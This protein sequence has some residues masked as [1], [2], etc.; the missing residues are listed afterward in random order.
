MRRL[1]V[2]L[3]TAFLAVGSLQTPAQA[4]VTSY[5]T[6]NIIADLNP[7]TAYDEVGS[8]V[9]W[10]GAL[11]YVGESATYGR[12]LRRITASGVS[13][14]AYDVNPDGSSSPWAL[15]VFKGKLYFYA[16]SSDGTT[17]LYSLTTTGVLT[18]HGAIA[19]YPFWPMKDTIA[20]YNN[21]LYMLRHNQDGPESSWQLWQFDGNS[22]SLTPAPSHER[23][24]GMNSQW[25]SVV[26]NKLY[27]SMPAGG[28]AT[29]LGVVGTDGVAVQAPH[30]T[31]IG[32]PEHLVSL[33]NRIAL[34]AS[35]PVGTE[36][37]VYDGNSEPVGMNVA[38]DSGQVGSSWPSELYVY[39][40]N[41]YFS[42]SATPGVYEFWRTDGTSQPTR[43]LGSVFTSGVKVNPVP[44]AIFNNR[45]YF[46]ALTQGEANVGLFSTDGNTARRESVVPN[47]W[48]PWSGKNPVF[49]G[50]VYLTVD[51]GT[52]PILYSFD[53]T[54]LR[55]VEHTDYATGEGYAEAWGVSA[56]ATTSS[57]LYF[58]GSTGDHSGLFKFNGTTTPT[59]VPGSE[60][61]SV[62][63]IF[64]LGD[65]VYASAQPRNLEYQELALYTI[66]V[67]AEL[68]R[69]DNL[70]ESIGTNSMDIIASMGSG[71]IFVS[72]DSIVYL[73]NSQIRKMDSS[74]FDQIEVGVVIGSYYYF[75]VQEGFGK[76]IYRW[77]GTNSPTLYADFS[78]GF[79][80][81][82][83]LFDVNGELHC[84][85][86]AGNG[87][88]F[89]KIVPSGFETIDSDPGIDS[90]YVRESVKVG[91]AT[92]ITGFQ[93]STFTT[94]LWKLTSS[95]IAAV[96]S[97]D[98]YLSRVES[99]SLALGRLV[100]TG[101]STLDK[102]QAVVVESDGSVSTLL[103]MNIDRNREIYGRVAGFNGAYYFPYQHPQFGIELAT[104]G[105]GVNAD[106]SSAP[107]NLS[108]GVATDSSVALSWTAPTN[109]GGAPLST[110]VVEYSTN[111]TTWK[112]FYHPASTAT[113]LV[114]SGLNFNTTYQFR[115]KARTVEGNSAASSTASKKTLVVRPSAVRSVQ[116]K[117]T[118]ITK[119][120]AKVTWLAPS[121]RG[122]GRITDY[123]VET[124]TNGKKWTVIKRKAST[125]LSITLA[126]LKS[127]TKYYVR[128]TVVSTAG[129]SAASTKLL[130]KTK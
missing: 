46:A 75:T 115:V 38:D 108:T 24:D 16:S 71:T 34:R 129:N 89:Q 106:A 82:S 97:V 122:S 49:G 100:V 23:Q 19:S 51:I 10:N 35:G 39:K 117:P 93:Y 22:F 14:L 52:G 91:N 127:K 18:Q 25:V 105:S 56:F 95:G 114:V 69:L 113:N 26:N 87:V 103:N 85:A 7:N 74:V 11:Y 124:S 116:V 41:L 81:I 96:P 8:P 67:N 65:T 78:N 88:A 62:A 28:Y 59:I 112:N 4:S 73:S 36:V 42:A 60:D 33:G 111:G 43:F 3:I 119:S 37:Y 6:P 120:T 123:K 57:G 72:Y 20:V 94:H 64:N 53:G 29:V 70:S 76:A 80:N 30:T 5:L 44:M 32:S 17:Y 98:T 50:K 128:I 83:R 99:I 79:V 55:E 84:I 66:N 125:A 109:T 130:F 40:N 102:Y 118:G 92:Y 90:T 104:T 13:E 110:Y 31:T 48:L 121:I 15:T 45:L 61:L 21:K 58:A 47:L 68:E 63:S 2:I 126:K 86:D 9:E 77:D 54:S 12:E 1:L 107:T 27:F 101:T